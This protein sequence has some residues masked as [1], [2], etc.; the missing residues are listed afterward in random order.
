MVER[1]ALIVEAKRLRVDEAWSCQRIADQLGVSR[2]TVREW[3]AGVP[4]PEWTK[5][6]N[7]KDDL[8]EQAIALRVQ[9]WS[10][11]DIA[12]RIGVAK[13]TAYH[14]VRHIPLDTHSAR[15]RQRRREAKERRDEYWVGYRQRR[16][17][18]RASAVQRA[19]RSTID[20]SDEELVRLGAVM[21]WCEG[22]KAK[23]WRR[24]A[25]RLV[26]TNSDPA[27]IRLYLRFLRT[28]GVPGERVRY[29]VA[30]HESA[31][32]D[33]AVRWWAEVVGVSA[34]EFRPTTLK[35]HSAGTNR[36]NLGEDYHG[37]LVIDVARSRE[38][39][40]MVEG[41]VRGLVRNV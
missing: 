37:C 15:A 8:Y 18:V 39:Y 4:V 7:A 25:E 33:K 34:V 22:T 16:D 40:W 6:P 2:T 5:R 13:S 19:A 27:L 41:I 3:L 36:R 35:R 9:G 17:E 10:V 29:R 23:P 32:S 26:F 38:L 24:D 11:S 12:C 1:E 30:I 31:D 20:L 28:L 14:W 21:Y